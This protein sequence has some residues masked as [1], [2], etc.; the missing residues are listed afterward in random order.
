M[1]YDGSALQLQEL[2]MSTE[3]QELIRKAK[4]LS[5][6]ERSQL[7]HELDDLAEP[8]KNGEPS[9]KEKFL[10]QLVADGVLK[11]A[12]RPARD[13]ERFHRYQPVPF[14]GPPLSQTIIEERR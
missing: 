5:V 4:S 9:A 2:A 14:E 3:L 6:E 1:G 13:S 7:R 8:V 11:S 10:Q 12:K